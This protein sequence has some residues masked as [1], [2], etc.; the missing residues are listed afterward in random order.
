MS[1]PKKEEGDTTE[2]VHPE[3][4]VWNREQVLPT[5]HPADLGANVARKRIGKPNEELEVE[6]P[7]L[8]HLDQALRMREA[9]Q[10]SL[11]K[12][13]P[14]HALLTEKDETRTRSEDI[15][16]TMLHRLLVHSRLR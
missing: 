16:A 12:N 15:T 8:P 4:L 1:K 11:A 14:A 3:H 6:N 7:R 10:T 2:R 13:L 9:P 5:I